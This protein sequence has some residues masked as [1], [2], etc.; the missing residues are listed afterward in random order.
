MDAFESRSRRK[1]GL[2]IDA[3]KRGAVENQKGPKALAPAENRMAQGFRQPGRRARLFLLG[4][5]GGEIGFHD[6]C[7]VAKLDKKL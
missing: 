7:G 3:E 2:P 4:K 1:S 5:N 6:C